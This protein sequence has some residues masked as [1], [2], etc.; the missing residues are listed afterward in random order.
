[1]GMVNARNYSWSILRWFVFASLFLLTVSIFVPSKPQLPDSELDASWEVVLHWAHAQP[2]TFGRDLVFTYGPWGFILQGYSPQTF[3]WVVAGWVLY[4]ATFFTALCVL[5]HRMRW[6]WWWAGLWMLLVLCITSAHIPGVQDGWLIS[7]AVALLLIHFCV[8]A[9]PVTFFKFFAAISLAWVSLGKFSLAMPA[10]M[11]MFTIAAE[12][13]LRRKLPKLLC[14]YIVSLLV[15]W[16]AA[17][18]SFGAIFDYL[19]NSMRVA[20]GFAQGESLP[21]PNEGRE[22]FFFVSCGILF[23]VLVGL[24]HLP[25]RSRPRISQKTCRAV[26]LIGC[27]SLLLLIIFKS[28]YVRHDGHAGIATVTLAM[29]TVI[30][31]PAFWPMIRNRIARP[32]VIVVPA[33]CIALAWHTQNRWFDVSFPRGMLKTISGAPS[34]LATA[35]RILLDRSML[36][37]QQQA[38]FKRWRESRPLP[39]VKGS[40]DVLPWAQRVVLANGLNYRPRPVFQSYLAYSAELA[41]LN[42]NFFAGNH[43]PDSVLLDVKGID[44]HLPAME[45]GACW[46]ELLARYSLTD[47]R[48]S[49]LLLSRIPSA[50]APR[51][52]PIEQRQGEFDQWIRLPE[53]QDAMWAAIQLRTTLRGKLRTALYKP[54]QVLLELKSPVQRITRFRLSP[55]NRRGGFLL[56]PQ[57]LDRM[58]FALLQSDR[59]QDQLR[60]AHVSEMRIIYAEGSTSSAYAHQYDV[61]FSSLKF[62]RRDISGVPGVADYLRFRDFTGRLQI[63]KAD[64]RPQTLS[65]DDGRWILVCPGATQFVLTTPPSSTYL[66][67]AFGVLSAPE[68][69]GKSTATMFRVC[70][71]TRD[72]RGQLNSTPIWEGRLDT[73]KNAVDSA[74]TTQDISLPYPIPPGVLLESS[75]ADPDSAALPFWT[76]AAFR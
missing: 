14:V 4:G 29:L 31:A 16:M 75:P 65:T 38:E 27:L 9:R 64:A 69:R 72:V 63:L 2:L 43:A 45:D 18:Q 52:T 34:R 10:A 76:D 1:M 47:A 7:L 5:A 41:E 36:A 61:V 51:V 13:T 30:Q 32:A 44:D 70:G 56:S 22:I 58:S 46:P 15:L 48:R 67:I 26:L 49:F 62:P 28:G 42:A 53:S 59:W 3:G 19:R 66:R 55:D 60:D 11:V 68:K 8:D 6:R 35:T 74:L 21:G 17:G 20:V 54:P 33:M 39:P 71:V 40:V 50:Q 25:L 23:L 73:H 12:E 24:A 57:I 37:N